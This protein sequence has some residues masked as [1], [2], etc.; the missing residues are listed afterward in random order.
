MFETR[1]HRTVIPLDIDS[2][3]IE[4]T[5]D[6]GEV[7]AGRKSAPIS[8]VELELK[9]GNPADLFKLARTLIQRVPARLATRSKADRGYDLMQGNPIAAV[10]PQKINL[11]PGVFMA[12]AFRTIAFSCLRD[13]AAN[14]MAVSEGDPEGVHQMRVALRRLRAAISLFSELLDDPQTERIKVELKWLAGELAPARDLDVFVTGNIKPLEQTLPARFGLQDLRHDLEAQ[15]SAA[16]ERARKAVESPRYR[17]LVLDVLSWLYAGEWTGGDELAHARRERKIED[18]ARE[19]LA[20]RMKKIMKIAKTLAELDPRQRHK[21]RIAIKKLRYATE[22]FES[23]F[24]G[25]KAK[26]RLRRFERQLKE[27]QDSLGALNDIIVHQKLASAVIGRDARQRARR[28]A[29]AV[30][31]VSG[32]EQC[33][34]EPL[35]RAATKATHKLAQVRPF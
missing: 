1:V 8:E 17:V 25:R 33:R 27:L 6:Q 5:F 10:K 28:R 19:Q 21:L 34:V 31:V 9:R 18:F 29:F 12:E 20:R 2:S 4:V 22:F 23:V 30:G 3:H 13:L 15:R 35:L 16:F 26:K 11:E 14:E 24:T 32:R 7:R